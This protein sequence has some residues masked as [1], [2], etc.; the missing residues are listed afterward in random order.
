MRDA[1]WIAALLFLIWPGLIVWRLPLVARLDIAARLAIAF[2]AGAAS[3]VVILYAYSFAHVPWTRMSVGIPLI[4]LGC[5]GAAFRPPGRAK[6]RRYTWVLI[7]VFAALT[8]YGVGTARETCADLI[9][10][11]GPKTQHFHHVGKIDAEFLAFPHYYLMHPDYPP[12]V[13]LLYEWPSLVAHRFSWWGALFFTPVA[14][15]AIA[16]A[17]RGLS[18]SGWCAALLTAILAYGFAIGMVA[19]A[20]DPPLLLFEVV[21]ITALT[22]AGDQRD[23]QIIGAVALAAA[24]FTKVEG[25]AFVIVA[26]IAYLIV[27]RKIVRAVLIAAPS[28]VLLGSWIV[29][30]ARHQLLD[31]YWNP[32]RKIH[33]EILG[34]VIRRTLRQASYDVAWVPWIGAAAPLAITRRLRGAALPLL[35]AAGSAASTIFF[36]LHSDNPSWWI[37]SSAVRVLLTPLSCLVVASA[38][39]VVESPDDGVVPQ[40]KETE[41][42]G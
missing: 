40:G 30:S 6:A 24:A 42:S 38:A 13:P 20:A 41:G 8:I 16:F 19:G 33:L 32:T 18:R 21:A 17:F 35:V 23:G 4:I 9:Y 34:L 10:F 39:G 1:V 26:V 3:V 15:L 12:L 36:Y 11:W 27:T 28:V 37:D 31:S 14:L 25:A 29:F 22:F 7:A 5:V 2:V